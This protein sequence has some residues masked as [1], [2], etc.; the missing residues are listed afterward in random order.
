MKDCFAGEGDCSPAAVLVSHYR[1]CSVRDAIF[2]FLG[3][4][5][6]QYNVPIL[7]VAL[8]AVEPFFSS[9]YSS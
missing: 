6:P 4:L 2:I 3:T 1:S 7:R 5:L 8:A 9:F